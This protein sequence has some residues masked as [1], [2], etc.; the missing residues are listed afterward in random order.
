MKKRKLIIALLIVCCL[1]TGC[2]S[3]KEERE[4]PEEK[5]TNVDVDSDIKLNINIDTDG[6]GKCDVNCDFDNDSVADAFIDLNKDNLYNYDDIELYV[7][8]EI[9]EGKE[10]LTIYC[11]FDTDK[12]ECMENT[13]RLLA[14]IGDTHPYKTMQEIK[15]DSIT[16]INARCLIEYKYDKDLQK[17]LDEKVNNLLK[18]II[19]PEM[20]S[21][22]SKIKAVYD[23]IIDN[24]TPMWKEQDSLDENSK[25]VYGNA[26][27]LLE[28]HKGTAESYAD[29]MA[30][31]L[32]KMGYENIR[33]YNEDHVWN[34]VKV[35]NTWYHIDASWAYAINS[36]GELV[37]IPY[38]Y[39]M[40]TEGEL[41]VMDKVHYFDKNEFPLFKD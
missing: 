35:D 34:A 39:F 10:E 18:T 29:L 11:S 14:K 27:S 23:Y 5:K 22:K 41:K 2:N 24:S 13:I 26:N 17:E 16:T 3:K 38:K 20:K 6:D 31:F 30:I 21:D 8:K 7:E 36:T 33:V 12:E 1:L 28:N 15:F 4:I 37:K 32:T 40:V 19:T 9:E 25:K